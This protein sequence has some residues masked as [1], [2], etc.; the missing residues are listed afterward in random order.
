MKK[1]KNTMLKFQKRIDAHIHYAL[2][3][4]PE[5]LIRF[6]DK[7]GIDK[8]NLVLVPSRPRLTAV[9][10]A[11]M[12]KAKY[13]QRFYVFTSMD[14]SEY[15]KH[16]KEIGKYQAKFVDAM[17]KCG[18][19][20]LKIIEGKPTM[21]KIMGAIPGFDAPCW[22]PLWQYLEE[23]QFPVLW[24]LNDPE[25]CW[26][27]EEKAPRHIRLGKELYDDTFVNNEEQYCQMEAI[28]ERHPKIKFIFAHLYFM[29]AQLPRLA[30]ILDK[31]PNVMVDITPG[32]EIYVNLSKNTEEAKSF[33]EKYQDR[34]L[35]GT[36]IG[37]RC[38][39]AENAEDKLN[40]DECIARMDLIDGLFD[41]KINRIMREDGRYLINTDDFVQQGFD[42]T[43]EAINKI[44]WKNFERYVG[45]TPAKVNPKLIKKECKRIVT[46]LKIM[47]FIDKSMKPD[48]SVAKDAIA[49]F[50]KT[51]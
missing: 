6:M 46:T 2:P 11:L 5:T 48:I 36:D 45:E 30:A 27:P 43:E 8:A 50:H 29:S 42:L 26:G 14:V 13:P 23:T 15:F 39:L 17:R 21:R 19:D 22:E 41:S 49:F 33:F 24:H 9:P 44:Y 12:A 35:Y 28:L 7:N 32:L 31:Y 34:I 40:E 1:E 37:A 10:D 16:G 38:V 4:T 25:S 47:S 18:C 3:L 51:K 20:G